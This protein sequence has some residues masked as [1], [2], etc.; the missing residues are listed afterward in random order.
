MSFRFA[1]LAPLWILTEFSSFLLHFNVHSLLFIATLNNMSGNQ[2]SSS[3]SLGGLPAPPSRRPS[4]S[5]TSVPSILE[6]KQSE[7]HQQQ[8]PLTAP[9]PTPT[10]TLEQ[11]ASVVARNDAKVDQVVSLLSTLIERTSAPPPLESPSASSHLSN[12][13]PLLSAKQAARTSSIDTH[14]QQVKKDVLGATE[15]DVALAKQFLG[16]EVSGREET[17]G[18]ETGMQGLGMGGLPFHSISPV[19][20]AVSTSFGLSSTL[21]P[22][23]VLSEGKSLLTI[24]SET[25]TSKSTPS[26]SKN[27]F[28]SFDILQSTIR[29][30][31]L[32]LTKVVKEAN[33]GAVGIAVERVEQWM[34]YAQFLYKLWEEHGSAAT[35]FY[36]TA[37]FT[38]MQR[39]EHSLFAVNGYFD[40]ET[41]TALVHRFPLKSKSKSFSSSSSSSSSSSGKQ[42]H[43]GRGGG[44]KE[45]GGGNKFCKEHGQCNHITAEC[46]VL[47]AQSSS[48]ASTSKSTSS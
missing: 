6:H 7:T 32:R 23:D 47:K 48:S 45:F 18:I 43:G 38:K 2:P 27:K 22:T 15:E 41:Y 44:K 3:S 4:V 13:L 17:G 11:L 19:P 37:V 8:P 16:E 14:M 24:L 36:H 26:S 33:G 29:T 20:P 30:E 42:Q 25:L 28:Q 10:P 35:N 21:F 31:F 46:K 1:L 40:A 5:S 12:P 39:G 34:A 9:T